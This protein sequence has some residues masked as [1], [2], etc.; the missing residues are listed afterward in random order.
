MQVW[1][2]AIRKFKCGC[3]IYTIQHLQMWLLSR[4]YS[5]Y[6]ENML[7]Y[8]RI[9]ILTLVSENNEGMKISN[10]IMYMYLF[11]YCTLLYVIPHTCIFNVYLRI[12]KHTHPTSKYYNAFYKSEGKSVVRENVAVFSDET[13]RVFSQLGKHL[14]TLIYDTLRHQQ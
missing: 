11:I 3:I 12:S 14:H 1:L 7:Q 13:R 6:A 5:V 8:A 10:Q 2:Y 9:E 4:L